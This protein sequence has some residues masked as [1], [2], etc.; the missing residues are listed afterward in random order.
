MSW[1]SVIPEILCGT[2]LFVLPGLLVAYLGG[3][4]GITAW[5]TAPLITVAVAAAV[6]IVAGWLGVPFG[7]LSCLVGVV[8]AAVVAL[9]FSLILGRSVLHRRGIRPPAPDGF[10]YTLA[11]ALGT[12]ASAVIGIATFVIGIGRPDAISQTWDSVFHYNAIRYIAQSGNASAL[13]LGSLN[14]PGAQGRFYPAAWHDMAGLLANLTG[15]TPLV[16]AL[17]TCL[18]VA[19]VVWPLGCVLLC[20]HLFG[21]SG[22]RAIAA[23]ITTG[24]VS[25]TF[26]PFP[27]Q[28]TGWGVLWPNALGM[29]LAP[30]GIAIGLS[31]LRMTRDDGFGTGRRWLLAVTGA[32]A[33]AVSHPNSAISVALVLI[34]PILIMFG[35]YLRAE[36]RN[37]H[38]ARG[39]AVLT[40]VAVVVIGGWAYAATLPGL[41][42]VQG[43][44]WPPFETAPQAIGESFTNGTNQ[45]HGA[46]ILSLFML[47]GMV[48]CFV[49]RTRRWLV[50]A[51]LLITALYVGSAA[52]GSPFVRQFTGFWYDDSHRIAAMLPVVA[53][54]L[55]VTGVLATGLGMYRLVSE[56]TTR[57]FLR[58]T[59]PTAVTISLAV[60]V[61]GLAALRGVPNNAL[62]LGK[63]FSTAGDHN[64][65]GPQKRDFFRAVDGH[66]PSKALVANDPFD[67]TAALWS[68]TGTR[69]L[70]PQVDPTAN[71]KQ[72]SYLA[73]HLVDIHHDSRVCSL[74]RKYDV[75]FMVIAPDNY[76]PKSAQPGF[77]SGIVDPG[78]RSGFRLVVSDGPRKLY[79]I[80]ECHASSDR[81]TEQA[82][83]AGESHN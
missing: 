77:Y 32:W 82:T 5:A 74:V 37:R 81:R 66:V 61:A 14:Q 64:L 8:V 79:R 48:M 17:V 56:R 75:N 22:T 20:R 3:L 53:V 71:N 70:F 25:A 69:V 67:G 28:I 33:I 27:W 16:A 54:P 50:V 42:R 18:V 83:P 1:T 23:V 2:A 35:R 68:L 52:I 80:T 10:R 38:R 4:R 29:A 62:V 9:L 36:Y 51:Q 11:A 34:A 58:T 76:L 46:L 73:Q 6:G 49:W 59:S 7:P 24:L 40:L 13:D 47:V 26:G 41:Q 31:I 55:A 72:M 21:A 57:E 78:S 19:A 63:E 44:F 12:A 43:I 30:T 39:V 45:Q 65:V 60:V 15:A